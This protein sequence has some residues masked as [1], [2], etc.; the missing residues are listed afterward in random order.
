MGPATLVFLAFAVT[1]LLVRPHANLGLLTLAMPALLGVLV[2]WTLASLAWGSSSEAVPE[3]E[4]TLMYMSASLALAVVL[5][6]G[7]TTGVLIGLWAGILAISLYA[8]A[9]RLFPEQLAVFDQIAGYRLSEP[10]GYWNALGLLASFGLLLAFGLAGRAEQLLVRIPAAAS[11]VPLALTCYFTFSRGAW[12][13]LTAGLLVALLIDPRRLQL[14]LTAAVIAP[15]CGCAVVLASRSGPLTEDGGHTLAA[16]AADGRALAAVGVGL[17]LFAAGAV[18]ILAALESRV[19]VGSTAQRVGSGAVVAGV[20]ALVVAVVL[21]LGGPAKI[22]SSFAAEY[23]EQSEDLDDR[24]FSLSGNGRVDIWRVGWHM[25]AEHPLTGS[26]AGSYQ[27]HWLEE[28]PDEAPVRDAHSFYLEMLAE[29][30]PVGLALVVALF[31]FP[32]VLAVKIAAGPSFRSRRRFSSRTSSGRGS[33]GIGNFRSSPSWRSAARGSS[34]RRE[35]K[36]RVAR[37]AGV[38]SRSSLRR[39]PSCRSSRSRPSAIVPRRRRPRHSPIAT[40]RERWPKQRRPSA[41]RRGRSS[42]W[43]RSAARRQLQAIG[44]R[45]AEPSD[46]PLRSSPGTGACGSSWRR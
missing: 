40:S 10:V 20:A 23:T 44:R 12:L 22:A 13:G 1:A 24:L 4:R 8:L 2:V 28:R 27:R 29:L 39:S 17:A 5:R 11:T 3:V 14:A 37:S 46:A 42:P 43:S 38:A 9:T 16:A 21:V 31:G 6:R 36:D 18:C 15:W 19:R 30:G 34:S 7:A 25:A 45:R 33:T 26:G 41:W 35:S 32:L